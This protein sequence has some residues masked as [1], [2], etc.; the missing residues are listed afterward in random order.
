MVKNIEIDIK[1]INIIWS[2]FRLTKTILLNNKDSSFL[3]NNKRITQINKNTHKISLIK[4]LKIYLTLYKSQNK[5]IGNNLYRN[6][7]V[8]KSIIT[9]VIKITLLICLCKCTQ[10]KTLKNVIILIFRHSYKIF[11]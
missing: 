3:I 5:A 9:L 11:A 7:Y 2:N 1:L 4:N 10:I 6:L 8:V